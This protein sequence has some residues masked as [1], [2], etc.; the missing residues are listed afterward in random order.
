[1]QNF[2]S[3]RHGQGTYYKNNGDKY[4][5]EWENDLRNGH[6]IYVWNKGGYYEVKKR[7]NLDNS[8]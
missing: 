7:I 3:I 6:G 4:I 1:M 5:G 8:K 2:F